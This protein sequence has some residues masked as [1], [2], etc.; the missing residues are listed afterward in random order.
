MQAYHAA[1]G[2]EGQGRQAMKWNRTR[3][4]GKWQASV[5]QTGARLEAAARPFC[6]LSP[7]L[8]FPAAGWISAAA[9]SIQT[10]G[11]VS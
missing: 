3:E 6:L 7:C 10:V 9:A 2:R 5:E 1:G 4:H 8:D 11:S